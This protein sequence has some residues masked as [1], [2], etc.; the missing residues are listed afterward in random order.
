MDLLEVLNK[1]LHSGN[2][3]IGV[4]LY[5]LKDGY[6]DLSRIV[7]DKEGKVLSKYKTYKKDFYDLTDNDFQ[8]MIDEIAGK[9][10]LI[11]FAD[12]NFHII[13][14]TYIK[15]LELYCD[16]YKIPLKREL[17]L[18]SIEDIK[19]I[20]E[21]YLMF[22]VS[23]YYIPWLLKKDEKDILLPLLTEY[24]NKLNQIRSRQK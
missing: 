20:A 11:P 19:F 1:Q 3:Q 6:V 2:K 4:L 18:F 12:D 7:I 5:Y 8:T 16:H 24:I 13:D 17:R 21:N 23:K 14:F 9:N 22:N 15:A 10:E